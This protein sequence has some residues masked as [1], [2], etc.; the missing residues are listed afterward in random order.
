MLFVFDS[1]M[2]D[3]D[4]SE[5]DQC[6]A[7]ENILRAFQ[8]SCHLLFISMVDLNFIKKNTSEHL[9]SVGKTALQTIYNR[10]PEYKK[11]IEKIDYKVVIFLNKPQ[12]QLISRVGNTWNVSL[13]FLANSGILETLVMGE[14]DLDAKLLLEFARQYAQKNPISGT[15]I[16]ARKKGGG[17][18]N[19]PSELVSYLDSEYSPCLCV[20]D[21]D[22]F[23]PGYS[24]S[25]TSRACKE[26]VSTRQRICE[27]IE[28]EE[29]EIENLIPIEVLDKVVD[30]KDFSERLE[31]IP[32]WNDDQWKYLDLKSGVS[33]RW[34]LRQ[35]DDGTKRYWNGV[36]SYLESK[37]RK[38]SLCPKIEINIGTAAEDVCS[39]EEIKGVG[40]KAL[41]RTVK[42]LEDHSPKV[43]KKLFE[44]DL[45]WE[46]IGKAAF[47]FAI[48]PVGERVRAIIR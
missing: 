48:A 44:N 18:S 25:L 13:L 4:A 34:I 14:N 17:G 33:L 42:Y 26:A 20:T 35:N 2:K 5:L 12:D 31:A 8:T 41:E 1:S 30:I 23:H 40:S 15:V 9:S 36:Q 46:S 32:N 45:R 27:Y 19:T 16:K 10:A 43:T 47:E 11:L 6:S 37:R 3:V 39:C 24:Q 22:K 38:C 28:F 21:S 29:R 7:L